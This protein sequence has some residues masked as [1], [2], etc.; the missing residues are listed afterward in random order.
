MLNPAYP[1]EATEPTTSREEEEVVVAHTEQE[2]TP[3]QVTAQVLERQLH[4]LELMMHIGSSGDEER[5][6]GASLYAEDWGEIMGWA[7]EVR[8]RDLMTLESLKSHAER[9]LKGE[10]DRDTLAVAGYLA[11]KEYYLQF[12]LAAEAWGAKDSLRGNPELYLKDLAGD[13]FEPD[14]PIEDQVRGFLAVNERLY[15]TSMKYKDEADLARKYVK[16]L[17]VQWE[18]E[19]ASS[20]SNGASGLNEPATTGAPQAITSLV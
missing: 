8:D 3:Q 4:T 10:I 6:W 7:D 14:W 1:L 20:H 17:R 16:E 9:F 15:A 19:H 2:L 13:G 11:N 12:G 18:Q 5:N